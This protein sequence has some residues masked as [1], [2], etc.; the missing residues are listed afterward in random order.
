M[1]MV[2]YA[3]A[4]LPQYPPRASKLRSVPRNLA[5]AAGSPP[6]TA[7]P[8]IAN[9]DKREHH[10][11]P[12][13]SL[14]RNAVDALGVAVP[15]QTPAF[16]SNPTTRRL[17][18]GRVYQLKVYRGAQHRVI[19]VDLNWDD[20]RLLMQMSK[21][22]DILRSWRKYLS[23]KSLRSADADY[24]YPQPIRSLPS[25]SLDV[26]KVERIRHFLHHP[27][28]RRGK[29]RLVQHFM[30]YP[31]HGVLFLER[32]NPYRITFWVVFPVGMTAVFCGIWSHFY[33]MATAFTIGSYM[34]GAEAACLVLVGI[35]N[36]VQF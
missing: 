24:V 34:V 10:H 1:G 35:L 29:N 36:W 11:H 7:L 4:T 16:L 26:F 17:I 33:D 28:M 25:A 19:D 5:R 9:V 6:Y 21:A 32:W 15:G 27:E 18:V 8:N 12:S 31:D 13:H 22:Y 14:Y 2:T 20:S 23:L 30:A 3:P